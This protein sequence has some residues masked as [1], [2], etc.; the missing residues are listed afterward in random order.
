[1]SNNLGV[2]NAL[3]LLLPLLAFAAS[4]QDVKSTRAGS[5]QGIAYSRMPLSVRAN[6]VQGEL[7][8]LRDVR[9][10]PS[11]M[12]ELW[13]AGDLEVDNPRWAFLK[14]NP[15]RKARVRILKSDGA[16]L[17]A[18]ELERPLARLERTRLYG[19][20]GDTYLLTVDYSAGWGS[21]SGPATFLLEV[22]SGRLSWLETTDGRTGKNERISLA[23]TL[24]SAWKIVPASRGPGKDIVQVL[25]R[26]NFELDGQFKLTYIRYTYDG[27]KWSK[28]VKETDGFWES[29]EGFPE[30]R[31]FP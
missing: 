21:Y 11:V 9:L 27:K 24:K 26:P 6:G 23:D 14:R 3:L 4:A 18:E 22:K 25:C 5:L 10:T 20:N 30:I 15:L 17:Q 8:I 29:D 28:H 1:M 12:E 2:T 19:E 13:G 7:Q 16:Q 31:L